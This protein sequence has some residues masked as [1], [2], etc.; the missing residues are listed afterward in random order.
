MR[1]VARLVQFELGAPG[2]DLFAEADERLND[3]AQREHFGPPATD[4]QH[5]RREARLRGGIAPQLVEHDFGRGIPLQV[6]DHAHAFAAGFVAD[7]GDAFDPL[8]LR[9]LG[10]LLDQHVLADLIGDRGEH[11]RLA[12]IAP[13]FDLVPR[14]H[15]D[16]TA[17][18]QVGRACARLAQDQ[19]RGGEIGAGN[20]LDQLFGGDRGVGDEGEAAVD[21]FAQIVRGDVGRHADRDAACAIDQQVGEARRK[22]GR[23]LARAIV[24]LREIDRILVEIVEQRIGDLFQPRLGVTHRGGRIGVHAAEV[25]LAV[26]QRHAHRPVLRHARERVIDRAVAVR[27]VVT[28][29]VADDLG[30]LAIGPPGDEAAFLAGEEDPAVDRLQT[31]AHIGQR[32][33]D[34]HA[35]RVIEIARLHLIDDVDAVIFAHGAGRGEGVGF[36]AQGMSGPS[37]IRMRLTRSRGRLGE[38]VRRCQQWQPDM[39]IEGRFFHIFCGVGRRFA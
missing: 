1:P 20:V 30:A 37:V 17:T 8:V 11:D 34:D 27:V 2:D 31:V 21:H 9:G 36:V 16:R 3:V 6:H 18:G 7:V 25:A 38:S 15:H 24:V 19:G 14:P 29:H 4:R 23:F 5:V 28:H 33:A 35:H 13:G 39:G 26:D 10:D 22:H 32:A 12:I